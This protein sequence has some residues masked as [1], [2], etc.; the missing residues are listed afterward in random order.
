MV[1][2]AAGFSG[3]RSWPGAGDGFGTGAGGGFAGVWEG[4]LGEGIRAQRRGGAERRKVTR[5]FFARRVW[6]ISILYKARQLFLF[7]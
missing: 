5:D 7:S 2:G 6:V 3:A 1:V 4:V